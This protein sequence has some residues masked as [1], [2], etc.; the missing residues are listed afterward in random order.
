MEFAIHASVKQLLNEYLGPYFKY[1]EK[2]ETN[3]SD[4]V[5][6]I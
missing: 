5:F 3:Y 1:E 2:E 4:N 6:G